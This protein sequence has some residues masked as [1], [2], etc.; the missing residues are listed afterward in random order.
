MN[1]D[2]PQSFSQLEEFRNVL[3]RIIIRLKE[4]SQV[5]IVSS[6]YFIATVLSQ[7]T[8]EKRMLNILYFVFLRFLCMFLYVAVA[9][10]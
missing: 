9:A 7:L 10:V 4:K 1:L 8:S 6:V 3:T 5:I 2:F